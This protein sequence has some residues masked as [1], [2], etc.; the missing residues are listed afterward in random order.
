[1][2]LL[3]NVHRGATINKVGFEDANNTLTSITK[4][5]NAELTVS[6]ADLESALWSC[7]LMNEQEEFWHPKEE[8][9]DQFVRSLLKGRKFDKK[10][11]TI[12]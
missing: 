11:N 2:V 10:Y 3:Y 12:E 4:S 1:M 5:M 8:T 6:I 9:F 7:N